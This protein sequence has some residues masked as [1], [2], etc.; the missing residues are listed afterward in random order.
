[1]RAQLIAL[2][3]LA[4]TATANAQGPEA[5]GVAEADAAYGAGELDRAL[6]FY[7]RLLSTGGLPA[8]TTAHVHLR[9]GILRAS[10]EGAQAARAHFALALAL[11]PSLTPPPE[12]GPDAQAVFAALA[13]AQ[14]GR[15]LRLRLEQDGAARDAP[16]RLRIIVEGAPPGA[17]GSLR[18]EASPLGST[19]STGSTPWVQ[20]FDGAPDE[21]EVAA[22]AWRGAGTLALSVHALDAHGNELAAAAQ[23]VRAAAAPGGVDLATPAPAGGEDFLASPWFWL[24]AGV[25]VR[26]GA[27]AV[28][29]G[30]L[31]ATAQD[32]YVFVPSVM[33]LSRP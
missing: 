32:T 12:L 25:V 3:L 30:V 17:I 8:S 21:V 20:R 2:G 11:D 18:V 7:D 10:L 22:A 28:T 9:I 26:G 13:G 5:G 33:G 23:D 6:S 19:A 16:F 27:A 15:P 29:A 31:L 1:M 14:A 4:R 24:I